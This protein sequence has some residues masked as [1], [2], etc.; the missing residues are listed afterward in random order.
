MGEHADNLT[1]DGVDE[2]I[3]RSEYT[4]QQIVELS[5]QIDTL[6]NDVAALEGENEALQNQLTGS[7][8]EVTSLSDAMATAEGNIDDTVKTLADISATLLQAR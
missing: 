3:R 4:D 6:T 7:Q 2:L 1:D 5:E 8:Q